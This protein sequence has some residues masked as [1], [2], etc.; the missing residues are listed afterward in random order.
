MPERLPSPGPVPEPRLG[1][2]PGPAPEPT[3]LA[4]AQ[5]LLPPAPASALRQGLAP[6]R[7]ERV[8]VPAPQEPPELSQRQRRRRRQLLRPRA[9]ELGLEPMARPRAVPGA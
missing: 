5:A 7:Q 8:P 9:R 1:P 6:G 2:E 3:L 4:R